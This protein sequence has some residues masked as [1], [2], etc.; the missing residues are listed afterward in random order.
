MSQSAEDVLE[1]ALALPEI[2]RAEVVARLQESM[3]GFASP[4]IAEAWDLE[5]AARLKA[6]DD[7]SV[8]MIPAEEVYRQLR[9]KYGI[10]A[11]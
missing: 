1:A 9:E 5:I 11:D 4:E 10:F 7:G 2:E 3:S 8:E 6:I